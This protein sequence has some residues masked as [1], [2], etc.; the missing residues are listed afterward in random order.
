MSLYQIHLHLELK[1]FA[2]TMVQTLNT[3]LNAFNNHTYTMEYSTSTDRDNI[4]TFVRIALNT[5]IKED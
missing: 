2:K 1:L 4:D 3:T 5:S